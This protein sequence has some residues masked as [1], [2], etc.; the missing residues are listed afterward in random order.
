MPRQVHDNVGFRSRKQL[1]RAPNRRGVSLIAEFLFR[2][3]FDEFRASA[4]ERALSGQVVMHP[5]AASWSDL[6][7]ITLD[8]MFARPLAKQPPGMH[9][10]Q[11]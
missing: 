2:D 3:G 8:C 11:S 4:I 6:G 1:G 10:F 7:L 9:V 5:G